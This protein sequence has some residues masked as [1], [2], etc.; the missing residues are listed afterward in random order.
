MSFH[1]L[2]PRPG[3]NP[4]LFIRVGWDRPLGT[5]FA[6]VSEE[7]EHEE[8]EHVA[9]GESLEAIADPMVV[10][11]AVAPYAEIPAGLDVTLIVDMVTE[12]QRPRA[13]I[14]RLA[15]LFGVPL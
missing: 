3:Q 1:N 7:H 9:L 10:L 5:Y 12:G 11:Q 2:T 15:A 14:E 6:T 8:I 4:A 13:E